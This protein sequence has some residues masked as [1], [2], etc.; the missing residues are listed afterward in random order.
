MLHSKEQ[1]ELSSDSVSVFETE[2]SFSDEGL[3]GASSKYCST[4][5]VGAYIE[6]SG[7]NLLIQA[8]LLDSI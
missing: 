6:N 8:E 1:E 3:A 2:F 5:I 7:G 4:S